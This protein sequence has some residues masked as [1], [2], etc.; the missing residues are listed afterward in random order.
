MMHIFTTNLL[1]IFFY[2]TTDLLFFIVKYVF[3]IDFCLY[4]NGCKQVLFLDCIGG[5]YA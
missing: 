5:Y 3:D 4:D 1:Y 2:F